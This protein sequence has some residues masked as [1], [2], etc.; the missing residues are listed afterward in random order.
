MIPHAFSGWSPRAEPSGAV[1]PVTMRAR[2][3]RVP[4]GSVL[5]AVPL[6]AFA[7]GGGTA[8]V[9]AQDTESGAT[10]TNATRG[11]WLRVIAG[12]SPDR[13][14]VILGLWALHPYEP[15]F[16]EIDG[17]RGFGGLWGHWFAATLVNSYD[18]RTFIL[19]VERNW[20][21]LRSG[22]FGAGAGYRVGLVSG[23]DERLIGVA[24]H[25]PVLPFAGVLAWAR[26]GFIGADVY[27]VY[28]AISLELSLVF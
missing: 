26:V 9:S 7:A 1:A 3:R 20:L 2:R 24:R 27:Y 4:M 5:L 28:R 25:T 16:P 8:A 6:L 17:T 14:R 18:E 15:Q 11:G 10:Q 21:S 22:A 19:G 13:D 12:T 23:Y